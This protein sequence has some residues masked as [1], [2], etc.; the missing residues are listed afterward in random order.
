MNR[1]SRC[2]W[3][4]L[5]SGGL[6]SC[7]LP[8]YWQAAEGQLGLLRK[9]VS[10]EKVL[11]DRN[12]D[13]SL[14]EKLRLV[15]EIRQFAVME[16]GL[17]DNASYKSYADLQRGYVVWNV[18]AAEEFSV[19]PIRWCFPFVGC[20]AYRG[21]FDEEGARNFAEQLDKRGLDTYVVGSAAYSTL[22]YFADPVLNTMLIRGEEY[23]VGVLFH[24]LAHQQLYIKDDSELSEAF[25]TTV[26]EYGTQRWF[27]T[28]HNQQALQLYREKLARRAQFA[29]LIAEQQGRL[30]E[31]FSETASPESMGVTKANVYNAIRADYQELKNQ[32]EGANEY[33]NWFSSSLNNAKLASVSIYRRWVPGL[34][35][36]L[37]VN[38]LPAFYSELEALS[39]LAWDDRRLHLESWLESAL[40][41]PHSGAA[42][43]A[44]AENDRSG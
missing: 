37:S 39:R 36:Y 13:Q 14:Q 18:V 20:V 23:L 29:Q 11:D 12:E 34:H 30:R 21:F 40:S 8:Y 35:W 3:L 4:V 33:D 26:E 41:G 15:S 7:S 25:A 2:I 5:L 10:I 28:R 19:D 27:K 42:E 31:A 38:G 16:L 32:W 9:R 17:P 6:I 22:G 43:R 44:V 24:E 1:F